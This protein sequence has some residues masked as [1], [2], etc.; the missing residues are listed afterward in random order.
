MCDHLALIITNKSEICKL[1]FQQLQTKGWLP[2]VFYDKITHPASRGVEP[3][4]IFK[5]P[6]CRKGR[7]RKKYSKGATTL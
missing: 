1:F 5:N 3:M 2:P 7:A 4:E 6:N